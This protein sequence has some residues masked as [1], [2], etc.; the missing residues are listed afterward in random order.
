MEGSKGQELAAYVA[1]SHWDALPG[2]VKWLS[3]NGYQ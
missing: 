2:K 1:V 3:E